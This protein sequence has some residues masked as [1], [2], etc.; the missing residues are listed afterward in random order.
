MMRSAT[1]FLP[2]S[3]ITFMN[4]D[5]STLPNFGSGRISRLGTSRR[6]GIF[7]LFASAG[8]LGAPRE[9]INKTLTYSTHI[10]VTTFI[11]RATQQTNT[12]SFDPKRRLFGLRTLGTVLGARLLT[13]FDALQVER[14]TNDVVT[15]TRQVLHTTAANQHHAVFLQVVAFAADVGND[16]ETVGQA[17]LGNLTQSGVRLLGGGGVHAGAHAAALRAVLHRRALGFGLFDLAP[18][19]HELIDGWHE[20][21]VPYVKNENVNPFGIS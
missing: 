11:R 5:S 9:L 1:A 21:F 16:F 19:T 8:T 7:H 3:M 17:H 12:V 4:L 2:P 6:R 18:V 10:R 14:T 15:H 13:V 20:L